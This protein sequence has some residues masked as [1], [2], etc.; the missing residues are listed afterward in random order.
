MIFLTLEVMFIT[1]VSDVYY[2]SDIF[3]LVSDVFAIVRI[4]LTIVSD[5]SYYSNVSYSC[6]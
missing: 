4:F 5:V 6:K 1:L 3:T 2:Y